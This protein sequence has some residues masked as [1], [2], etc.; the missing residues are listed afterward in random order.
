M[1]RLLAAF[2][3]TALA[4]PVA[5]SAGV[6]IRSVDASG[7]PRV[8]VTVVTDEVTKTAPALTEGGK[9]AAG[10]VAQNLGR[11]K[12]IVLAVDRS[13]SMRGK[14][15]EQA[16]AA[17]R[18]FVA[19][20]PP[21]DRIAISTYA[22]KAL[23]LTGFSTST[24]DADTALR[25]VTEVDRVQGTVLYDDLVLAT[26][27][28]AEEP[29]ASRVI[30]IV[31][32]G[33]ETQSRATLQ[34]VVAKARQARV[35]IYV[36]AIESSRF[37]P[38][39]LK[40]LARQTGGRYYGTASAATLKEVYAAIANELKRTWR[41][42]YLTA[43]VSGER[44]RIAVSSAEQGSASRAFTL[45]K[46]A[47]REKPKSLLPPAA[48]EPY[49]TAVFAFV[50]GALALLGVGALFSLGKADR[51]R[52]RLQ[53]HLGVKRPAAKVRRRG[54]P[55]LDALNGLFRA[56]ERA[57]GHTRQ[58]RAAQRLLDRAD[59]PLRPVEFFYLI[60]GSG[61]IV[62]LIAAVAGSAP[63]VILVA[64]V[65]GGL[66]PYAVVWHKARRRM[67]AFEN[68]L[69][70]LLIS[71]AASLKAGHSFRQSLQ[72]V[73]DEGM[74][75][76]GKEFRRVLTETQLGRPMDDALNEMA[77][78][79]GSKNFDFI[80]TAVTIQTQVGG[81]LATLFDM[82]ADT[83]R[84]RQQFARKIKSLT[85]MGR[86]SAYVLIGLPFFVAGAITLM[87]PG[88]M[89]PL[90]HTSAGHKLIALGL[91]MMLFGSLI[92]RKIVSFRG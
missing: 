22:T 31:T 56:T 42:E 52:N 28:L 58:W 53:P 74:E 16:V 12:S 34:D 24:I 90:Y 43:G 87:N 68:Q 80:I 32:D 39:P 81:S 19:A 67:N 61:L 10:L 25:T 77:L 69:P 33:N 60:A 89:D 9:P 18:A 14:P 1:R 5:A 85:A 4:L 88:Y 37:T 6:Q 62:G 38:G 84:Q 71:V 82:V 48:Y 55:H 40:Q 35:S 23:M 11:A 13:Q 8:R 30:I 57:L 54:R 17:A 27:A 47:G 72:S 41:L 92:L 49:G 64:M 79:M 7:Y 75:P 46:V 70:D 15:L 63:V 83:V 21:G 76:A 26:R 2:A 86:M 36:I 20:K 65:L 50:I 59:V 45:P 44:V 66:I 3:L 51:L 29:L 91:T 73:V 78:R